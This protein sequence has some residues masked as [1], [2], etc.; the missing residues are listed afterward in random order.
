MFPFVPLLAIGLAGQSSATLSAEDSAYLR[1]LAHDTWHCVAAMAE[2]ETGLPYDN[3]SRGE[4]TSVSNIGIYLS[5]VCAAKEMGLIDTGE[6]ERRAAK[7]LE[8]LEKLK[9]WH[10]F[11]Q[12]WNSVTKLQP[13]KHDPWIS[14][15]DTGNYA[16]GLIVASQTFPSLRKRFH[17]LFEAMDWAWFYDRT[18]KALIGGYDTSNATF[19]TK[20][21]LAVLGT[22]AELAQ[23]FAIARGA[24]PPS[25]W[26]TLDRST[27]DRYGQTYLK[28]GWQGG[29]LFMQ[30]I[31]GLWLNNRGTFL[32]R[33]SRAFAAAQIA[34][35]KA[36]GSPVWGWSACDNP[37][38]GYLGW[39]A[40]KDE[41]VTP[42][43]SVLAIE[44]FPADVVANLKAL[45]K[46]GLRTPNDGFLDSVN[47]I[48]GEKSKQFLMLDQGMLFLSLA[49]F[50]H[51]DWVRMQ[52]QAHP[53]VQK[54]RRLIAEFRDAG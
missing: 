25:F 30:F 52:F 23:F 38:G 42:H 28:P 19:N 10:G 2:P 1:S 27:E 18:Q 47:V 12:C 45:E 17:A 3:A 8:S 32:G 26:D 29:G 9:T 33:S 34:H 36:I 51:N 24:A 20:W 54:G 48:S 6:A 35:G 31:S 5:S 7:T 40:L 50:L 16:A 49:N 53:T 13:A 22:D 11:A 43:A 41:V 37:A 39:G 14:L 4:F 21:H 15:L 46:L 44:H